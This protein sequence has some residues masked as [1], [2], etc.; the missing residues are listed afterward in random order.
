MGQKGNTK[1]CFGGHEARR[2]Y[3]RMLTKEHQKL[4]KSS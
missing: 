2:Q 1:E 3:Q 4:T